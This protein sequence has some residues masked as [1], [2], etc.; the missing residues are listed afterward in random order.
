MLINAR[1][2]F[3]I[4]LIGHSVFDYTHPCDHEEIREVLLEKVTKEDE[5]FERNFFVRMKCTLTSKGRN[6]NL[7]SATYKVW[8][9]IFL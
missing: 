6:I 9:L 2:S 8:Y 4:D 5:V 1:V 3:Q 7:K